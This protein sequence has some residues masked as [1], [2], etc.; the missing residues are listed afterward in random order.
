MSL[1]AKRRHQASSRLVRTLPTYVTAIHRGKQLRDL[2]GRILQIG[3]ERDNALAKGA[4]KAGDNGHVLPVV[5]A[6]QDHPGHI[7]TAQE[8]IFEQSGR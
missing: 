5:G 7:W 1:D 2:F 8:L 3:V 4:L 6:E